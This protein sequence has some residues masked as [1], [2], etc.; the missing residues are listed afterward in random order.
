MKPSIFGRCS[1]QVMPL[2]WVGWLP[3]QQPSWDSVS[4]EYLRS[5]RYEILVLIY[6]YCQYLR[7]SHGW[8]MTSRWQAVSVLEKNH[9]GFLLRSWICWC[10]A[11]PEPQRLLDRP[12]CP[13]S[14][15]PSR[16]WTPSWDIPSGLVV[17]F[18][19]FSRV[20]LS[21]RSSFGAEVLGKVSGRRKNS[22][23]P[24]FLPGSGSRLYC[25]YLDRFIMVF[26]FNKE[27]SKDLIQRF[28][29]ENPDPNNEN[30]VGYTNKPPGR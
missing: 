2:T 11:W 9:L 17:S 23:Q 3:T 22:N 13:M 15:W 30:V 19:F 20:V 14:S 26:R 1:D 8:Q 16:M 27:D 25:R 12:S 7:I 18:F 10:W 4:E 6:T 5:D 29:T 24:A 28:L 21:H